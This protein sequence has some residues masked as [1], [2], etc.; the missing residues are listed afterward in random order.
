MRMQGRKDV[1]R[2]G[3]AQIWMRLKSLEHSVVR[4]QVQVTS[5]P[6]EYWQCPTLS[7]TDSTSLRL[8]RNI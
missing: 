8:N 4:L 1:T 6:L 7:G 5:R 2:L 3:I